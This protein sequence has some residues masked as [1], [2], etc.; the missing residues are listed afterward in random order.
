MVEAEK[1]E[2]TGYVEDIDSRME[3]LQLADTSTG[4]RVVRRKNRELLRAEE[5]IDTEMS[6]KIDRR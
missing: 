2:W 5:E 4:E 1:E 3:R 6:E